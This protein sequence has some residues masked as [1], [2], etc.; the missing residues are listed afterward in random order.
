MSVLSSVAANAIVW[1]LF[2]VMLIVSCTIAYFKSS[3]SSFI[4]ANGTQKGVPLALNF[5]ATSF[6]CGM[7]VAYPQMANVAGLHGLLVYSLTSALPMMLFAYFGPL[8][9]K[10]CPEGFLLTEWVYQR[11]GTVAG[12][13]LSICTVLNLFLYMVSEVSSVNL[14]YEA[15]TGKSG[16]A[17][18]IVQCV[19]TTIYTTLGGFHISFITDTIQTGIV[20]VL[21]VAGTIAVATNLKIDHQA[22]LDSGL[23]EAKPLGWKL[24][25]ILTVAIFTNDFFMSGFWLRTFAAR[26]DKD[27]FIG[28]AIATFVLLCV[29]TLVG[30]TGM[31]AVWAGY[32]PI[33]SSESVPFFDLLAHQ[34]AGIVG[35]V[36]AITIVISTCALDTLQSALVSTI[37]SS[38][39]RN[40]LSLLYVRSIVLI[41]MVPVVIVGLIA[42]DILNI[43]L[44]VDLLSSSVIPVMMFGLH[45]K[46]HSYLT[47]WEVVGGG[48][49]GILSVFIFGS[50][51]YH[52]A[53]EGGR[54]LLLLNGLYLDDW[55]VFGALVAAPVGSIISAFLIFVIRSILYHFWPLSLLAPISPEQNN[56][57]GTI[58]EDYHSDETKDSTLIFPPI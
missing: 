21:L 9:R 30:M 56:T 52:S 42:Q 36:L 13:Y 31:L 50:I 18:V 58:S 22:V 29:L 41:V 3:G 27:L 10:R 44:I 26:S 23:L 24:L 47:A 1:P 19:V 53:H 40:K 8:I 32:V 17:V 16:L 28:C 55:G 5:I 45:R 37:A 49:G 6:G 14:A 15:L 43:Y 39:F 51:Y 34:S 12:V 38:V 11:F 20:L 4:S 2:A 48:L 35:L 46:S 25:Y 57:K 33:A 54:L 7:L